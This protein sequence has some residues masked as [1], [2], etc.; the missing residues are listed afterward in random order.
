MVSKERIL[1]FGADGFIGAALSIALK[2]Q[3]VFSGLNRNHVDVLDPN[4]LKHVI[5]DFKPTIVINTTGK[6]AGI[7]GN[8]DSPVALM[9]E[10]SEN[11]LSIARV[12]QDLKISKVLQ[13]ASACVYPINAVNPSTPSDLGNGYIEQ[14]S[15][16]YATAKIFGIELFNAYRKQYGYQWSTIIPTNLYGFGDWKASEDGHVIAMLT[17][18]FIEAKQLKMSQVTVWGDGGSTRSFLNINDLAQATCFFISHGM[19]DK[20]IVNISGDR[21]VS[22]K[23]LASLIKIAVNYQG[24]IIFDDSKPNGVRKK[25]LNDEP[26]RSLGWKPS[27]NLNL[28]IQEYVRALVMRV[29]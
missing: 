10:N 21:E 29:R 6:V 25:L 23:E 13:F 5:S 17:K 19:F 27:I 4:K 2:K 1:L 15:K 22:I 26:I 24:E 7:Q 16:S 14:T 8:I 3:S 9:H 12:C 18:K 28:G 11:I 20:E